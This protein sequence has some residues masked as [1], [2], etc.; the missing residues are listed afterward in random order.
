[1][2]TFSDPL[3]LILLP[4]LF[5]VFYFDRHSLTDLPH[6]RRL[7]S[8]SLRMVIFLLIL[9][10]LAGLKWIKSSDNLS[11][12][13]LVDVSD[14]IRSRS[15]EF[16]RSFIQI[17]QRGKPKEDTAGIVLFAK[18]ALV[19]QAPV[20]DLEVTPFKSN[21]GRTGTNLAEAVRL[22]TGLFPPDSQKRMI[23]ISDGNQTQGN[24]LQEA[25]MAKTNDV[26]ISVIP[27][28]QKI[29]REVSVE[30]VI[31]PKSVK[32]GEPFEVRAV[33]RSSK[34]SKGKLWLYRDDNLISEPVPVEI[35]SE[36][37][38]YAFTEKIDQSGL[39]TYEIRLETDQDKIIE[40]NRASSF[41]RV[42]GKSKIL[43][44]NP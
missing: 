8:L 30:E 33:L 6:F 36:K 13:F 4:L 5:L 12:I 41:T 20:T 1:M 19:E 27:L 25:S 24:L 14:S 21:P 34:P 10:S 38:I 22:A 26:E 32:Q 28:K 16:A 37:K 3:F 29:E 11:V 40:N 43:I 44:V 7:I 15:E 39:Y 23:I 9:F 18:N 17:A 35:G 42:M 2:I 31:S